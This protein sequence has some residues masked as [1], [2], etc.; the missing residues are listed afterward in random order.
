MTDD[1]HERRGDGNL[2]GAYLERVRAC[3]LQGLA[4]S[5]R[6]EIQAAG[7]GRDHGAF[8]VGASG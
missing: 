2:L 4:A 7:G 8:A 3:W 1:L 6:R 5:F